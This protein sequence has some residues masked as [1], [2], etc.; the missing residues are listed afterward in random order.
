M[1]EARRDTR[2]TSGRKPEESF[3]GAISGFVAVRFTGPGFD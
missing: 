3:I 1:K 2:L